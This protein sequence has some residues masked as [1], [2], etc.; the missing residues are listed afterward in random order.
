VVL[1]PLRVGDDKDERLLKKATATSKRKSIIY[2]AMKNM[3]RTNYFAPI[4]H[5]AKQ[6]S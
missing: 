2:H 5:T 1:A 3:T 4:Y 6:Q